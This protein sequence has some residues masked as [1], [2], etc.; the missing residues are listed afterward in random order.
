M[1]KA[2]CVFSTPPTNTSATTPQSSRRGFLVEA[3]GVAAGGLPLVLACRCRRHQLRLRT[4]LTP[5]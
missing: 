1:P 2:D 3:A 4:P 5:N